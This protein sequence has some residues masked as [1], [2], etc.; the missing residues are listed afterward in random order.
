M[1]GGGWLGWVVELVVCVK[2]DGW[3]D[4][5]L[6]RCVGGWLHHVSMLCVVLLGWG[7]VCGVVLR[8]LV[9]WFANVLM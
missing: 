9:M 3:V 5:W 1:A 7:G 8:W 4:G 2:A 6:G